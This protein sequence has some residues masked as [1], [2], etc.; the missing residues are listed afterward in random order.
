[1]TPGLRNP[2][3]PGPGPCP[4]R[5][6]PNLGRRTPLLCIQRNTML[7]LGTKCLDNP[8]WS[9]LV[10]IQVLDYSRG[11]EGGTHANGSE[12]LAMSSF[13]RHGMC[14][15][16]ICSSLDGWIYLKLSWMCQV[17]IEV[18]FLVTCYVL[19]LFELLAVFMEVILMLLAVF[20]VCLSFWAFFG[21]Q[22]LG[23][24]KGK[25]L[26]KPEARSTLS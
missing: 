7:D 13:R 3:N 9:A 22:L 15:P 11:R 23:R 20:C 10:S 24:P 6:K 8:T 14:F 26:Q 25:C 18:L 17:F 4:Y 12:A 16:Y 1:M 21:C 2:P 5:T 19:C